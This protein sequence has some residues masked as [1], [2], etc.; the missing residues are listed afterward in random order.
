VVKILGPDTSQLDN[1]DETRGIVSQSGASSSNLVS[2]CSPRSREHI[3]RHRKVRLPGPI[4]LKVNVGKGWWILYCEGEFWKGT[5]AF[6][7][8]MGPR[9]A[10]STAHQSLG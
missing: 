3:F 7:S 6:T 8:L 9:L 2:G 1:P 5:Y 4:F 10:Y